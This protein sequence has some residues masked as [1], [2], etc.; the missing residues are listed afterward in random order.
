MRN[1]KS[2]ALGVSLLAAC[3]GSA[4][5]EGDAAKGKEVFAQCAPCHQIGP[6]AKNLIGPEL[7]DIV[8]RKA[9]SVTDYPIYSDGMKKLGES[10]FVWTEENLDKWIANPKA[11]LPDSSMSLFPGVPDAS[12]RANL[13]AY[14][15]TVTQ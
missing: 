7:N 12:D 8:G 15:K 10:G 13:M 4:F 11:M 5:A 3:G 2:F 6:D 9:A 14:L 1:L